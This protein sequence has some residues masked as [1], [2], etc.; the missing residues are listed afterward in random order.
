VVEGSEALVILRDGIVVGT[1]RGDEV[2]A[3][4]VVELIAAAGAQ[5]AAAGADATGGIV[6]V[7]AVPLE[8]GSIEAPSVAELAA[9]GSPEAP[10]SGDAG[11]RT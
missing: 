10:P 8:V 4:R 6:V 11:D 9:D 2:K 1:L 5:A 7:E 3:D